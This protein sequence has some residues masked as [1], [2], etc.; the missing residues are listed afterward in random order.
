MYVTVF[1]LLLD[2]V[3][4]WIATGSGSLLC[5]MVA[6]SSVQS[7]HSAIT[8]LVQTKAHIHTLFTLFGLHPDDI[9][10]VRSLRLL[11]RCYRN[12]ER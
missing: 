9:T 8:V 4:V 10:H 6:P 2:S 3:M 12:T 5:G 11:H 1:K 7:S